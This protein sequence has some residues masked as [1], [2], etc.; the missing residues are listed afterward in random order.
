MFLLLC[1]EKGFASLIL[2]QL[3]VR[4]AVQI[5][6]LVRFVQGSVQRQDHD[7]KKNHDR[8]KKDQD[9]NDVF[10]FFLSLSRKKSLGNR[11][12]RSIEVSKYRSIEV[13]HS[14]NDFH[15][16]KTRNGQDKPKRSIR[17]EGNA[18]GKWNRMISARESHRIKQIGGSTP[19]QV[20][21]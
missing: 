21:K 5:L 18:P 1:A 19:D 3:I 8:K 20:E 16:D 2:V 11:E 17:T 13:S 15:T 6:I 12:Y 14:Q 10:I 7:H 9:K 4:V